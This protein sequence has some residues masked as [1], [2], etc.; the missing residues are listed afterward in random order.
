MNKTNLGI[1]VVSILLGWGV[2]YYSVNFLTIVP[3]VLLQL[4]AFGIA[5]AGIYNFF[6]EVD[7]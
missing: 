7:D 6:V 1:M 3:P 5:L 2:I 4:S